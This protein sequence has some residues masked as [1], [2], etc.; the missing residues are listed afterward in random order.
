MQEPRT[1]GQQEGSPGDVGTDPSIVSANGIPWIPVPITI[2]SQVTEASD[3][4][5]CRYLVH[6]RCEWQQ[7]VAYLVLNFAVKPLKL[8]QSI[9]K[10]CWSVIRST[11]IPICTTEPSDC[12]DCQMFWPSRGLRQYRTALWQPPMACK[13]S[14]KRKPNRNSRFGELSG[15]QFRKELPARKRVR[16]WP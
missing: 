8:E 10:H 4:V 3:D 6:D 9:F 7:F 5:P 1:T 13:M 14:N 16:R 11:S 12:P 15:G 2:R